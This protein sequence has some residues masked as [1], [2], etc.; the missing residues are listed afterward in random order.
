MGGGV[1]YDVYTYIY[2]YYTYT[3]WYRGYIMFY[4]NICWG[5]HYGYSHL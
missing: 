3:L 5:S 2:I 1:P 4:L